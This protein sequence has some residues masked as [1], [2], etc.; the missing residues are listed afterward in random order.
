MLTHSPWTTLH[1]KIICNVV[2]IYVGQHC[3]RKLPVQC[4]PMVNRQL[5]HSK[6]TYRM[7]CLS[8]WEYCLANVVEYV[9]DNI[10]QE[11]YLRKRKL[12]VQCWLRTYRYTFSGKPA[13]SNMSGGLFINQVQYHRTI[14]ALFIQYCSGVRGTTM[15]RSRYWLRHRF[16][17]NI[18]K[19][20][21]HCMFLSKVFKFF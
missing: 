9:W 18:H 20:L 7:L 1:R 12:L 19:D 16:E 15:N 14:L 21:L 8:R 10:A 4:W 6:I 13:V 2:L 5:F 11:N 17:F 3:A